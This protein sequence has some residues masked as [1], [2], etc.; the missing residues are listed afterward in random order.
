MGLPYMYILVCIFSVFMPFN[1]VCDGAYRRADE[2]GRIV[3]MDSFN[4][5][6][7]KMKL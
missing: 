5:E 4:R 7:A 2:S 1:R 6:I 3:A